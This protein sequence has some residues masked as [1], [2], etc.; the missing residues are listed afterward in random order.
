MECGT[1]SSGRPRKVSVRK[2]T[3]NTVT[4]IVHTVRV[5]PL[6]VL[7]GSILVACGPR[8]FAPLP[9]G[10]PD[11]PPIRELLD[12]P[13]VFAPNAPLAAAYNEPIAD[14]AHPRDPGEPVLAEVFAALARA[15]ETAT[16]SFDRDRRLDHVARELAAFVRGGGHVTPGLTSFAMRARGVPEPAGRVML[17]WGTSAEA[18]AAELRPQA[19]PP[20]S[21]STIHATATSSSLRG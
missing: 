20:R 9:P 18:V 1:S 17:A 2:T 12:A 4:E 6:A 15:D 7:A 8:G 5:R 3:T 19:R 10:P 14:E 13:L 11:P 16:G 21:S